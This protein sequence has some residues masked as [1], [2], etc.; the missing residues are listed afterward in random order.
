[1]DIVTRGLPFVFAYV[2]DMRVASPT[3]GEHSV[4]LRLFFER[5]AT[6]SSVINAA[7]SECGVPAL[8]FLGHHLDGARI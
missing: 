1:M 3:L 8:N 5:L 2:D 6:S 4:P 7:K